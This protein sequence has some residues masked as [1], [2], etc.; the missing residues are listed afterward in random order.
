MSMEFA[1]SNFSQ[2][3]VTPSLWSISSYF[4]V[5]TLTM[6]SFLILFMLIG[7][8]WNLVLI[9]IIIKKRLF[10]QPAILLLLNL[11]VTN[12]LLC[13]LVMP[14]Q[15]I[16]GLA[17][18]FIFGNSDYARCRVCY[19]T[20][21]MSILLL[22]S[23]HNVALLSLDRFLYVKKPLQYQNIVTLKRV[24]AILALCWLV[25]TAF[26]ILPVFGIGVVHFVQVLPACVL[27]FEERGLNIHN[28][29]YWV[30]HVGACITP[31]T[32][33]L[34]TNTWM[35][36]IMK[37]S[38]RNG[39]ARSKRNSIGGRKSLNSI[40]RK[41]ARDQ[42]RLSQIF[43]ALFVSSIVTWLPIAIAIIMVA[44]ANFFVLEFTTFSFLCILSQ[45]VIHPILQV[46]LLRDVRTVVAQPCRLLSGCQC[47]S[48]ETPPNSENNKSDDK[49]T[50]C[51]KHCCRQNVRACCC[52]WDCA[53]RSYTV[54][55]SS[56][57]ENKSSSQPE[58][59][60]S[61]SKPENELAVCTD[62]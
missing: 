13:L 59:E 2:N 28:T 32:I 62:V 14:M 24:S 18:E 61:S 19:L 48:R 27:N 38:I 3:N 37:K 25:F 9:I 44:A 60:S 21:I 47:Y 39:Y 17:G 26:S 29:Y 51:T 11:A 12:F 56:Q 22:M 8:P 34:I 42:T 1:C 41:Y 52:M 43:V 30:F 16:P 50:T 5:A 4:R 10:K 31:V 40:R 15:I 55:R 54:N 33:L 20:L 23:V 49:A 45:P 58:N 53:G 35:L 7:I 6:S 57:L 36:C 46:L